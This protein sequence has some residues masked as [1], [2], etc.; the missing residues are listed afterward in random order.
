M[1]ATRFRSVACASLSERKRVAS[2]GAVGWWRRRATDPAERLP[3]RRTGAVACGVVVASLLLVRVFAVTAPRV[4]LA[5]GF[6]VFVVV[7]IWWQWR[8]NEM[9]AADPMPVRNR[10]ATARPR[11]RRRY[12][13][14]A[15]AGRVGRAG[16]Y[17]AASVVTGLPSRLARVVAVLRREHTRDTVRQWLHAAADALGGI[18][19]PD[20]SARALEDTDSDEGP[21]SSSRHAA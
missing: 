12:G 17:S 19:P 21:G 3:L 2:A 5:L 8:A 20:V 16:L 13:S 6:T 1:E 10:G 14:N 15:S 18:P 11:P 9:D 4:L 7:I